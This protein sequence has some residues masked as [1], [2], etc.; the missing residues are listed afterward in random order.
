[1]LINTEAEQSVLGAILL[2]P[3]IL[4]D[5]QEI[6][7]VEDFYQPSHRAIFRAAVSLATK[8]Q[9][10][11]PV[12]LSEELH[13]SGD[14]EQIGGLGY[15]TELAVNTPSTANAKI[16]AAIVAEY[17]KKRGL[18]QVLDIISKSV[19]SETSADADELLARAA[20]MIGSLQVADGEGLR[21]T[22][23]VLKSLAQQWDTRARAG[24]E[25]DGFETGL[26]DLDR[27]FMGWKPGD[28]I[29]I[30]GRPSMGKSLIAFQIAVR[31]A[32]ER[33]KRILAFS[34]EMTAER[35]LER[36]TANIGNIPLDALRKCNM[37]TFGEYS[38]TISATAARIAN[39]DM[40][41]D[42][43]PG[44]HIN[45]IAARARNAHRKKP[46]DLVVVDHI[47][48]ATGGGKGAKEYEQVTEIS[49]GLK[50]LAKE[51]G[52]PVLGVTQLNR[53]VENNKEK[54]P[55]MANLRGSGSI[56]QDADIIMLIY[57]ADYYYE[58]TAFPG[59]VE[60][61]TAKFREGEVGIDRLANQFKFARVADLCPI[62]Y[63]RLEQEEQNKP[64]PGRG[65][66]A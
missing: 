61:N 8:N 51:L 7:T 30:A 48:I 44:L 59:I 60:I 43:T 22:K 9:P 39:A 24:G 56:E 28:F 23:Q 57:R 15:I 5:I 41:I 66:N 35:L 63:Q 37:D 54:K 1:M 4:S 49:G 38:H 6:L 32:V 20:S 46:L 27:R 10:C 14:L 25:V 26:A 17:S 53:D 19:D 13:K 21:N 64:K 40:L 18:R 16:Y 50:K 65:F 52:C 47:N 31:A 12:T 3:S 34:L 62:E 58:D 33:G 36:A 2:D 42:E 55:S 29:V 45:Q 11:D